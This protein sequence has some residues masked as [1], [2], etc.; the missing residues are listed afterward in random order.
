MRTSTFSLILDYVQQ[1]TGVFYKVCDP[2][3]HGRIGCIMAKG[4]PKR[5]NSDTIV[6]KCFDQR[7]CL[8]VV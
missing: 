5:L 7:F 8:N 1:N 2:L 6:I 3:Y 4:I